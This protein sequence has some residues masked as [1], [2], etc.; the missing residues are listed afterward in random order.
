MRI[1]EGDPRRVA[2]I[3]PG[4]GYTPDRP[5]LHYTRMVLLERGWTVREHWWSDGD[6]TTPEVAFEEAIEVLDTAGRP[7]T[8]LVVGKSLGS[9]AAPAVVDRALPAV[10]LTPLL[11]DELV[12]AALSSTLEPALV[13]GGTGDGAWDGDFARTTRC[14]VHEVK[15][16]DHSLEVPGSVRDTL[17]VHE[18]AVRRIADFVAGLQY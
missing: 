12:R 16:A 9:L 14:E 15:H 2:T 8:H 17:K 5:L 6:T 3:L 4:R 13:L 7:A 1:H 18:R 11:R 10:W